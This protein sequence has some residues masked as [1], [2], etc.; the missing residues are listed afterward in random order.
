M[1]S[2]T[3]VILNRRDAKLS[4]SVQVTSDS[5]SCKSQATSFMVIYN[6]NTIDNTTVTTTQHQ[7]YTPIT[8]IIHHYSSCRSVPSDDD[9]ILVAMAS[10]FIIL[11]L[12]FPNDNE[13]THWIAFFRSC[14]MQ[15]SHAYDSSPCRRWMH[16]TFDW[17]VALEVAFDRHGC[18]IK[19][20]TPI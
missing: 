16:A 17:W 18:A 8:P 9:D 20:G 14:Q 12:D 19:G 11:G 3:E 6:T 1:A 4:A 5:S 2:V 7:H 13:A 15:F 10:L